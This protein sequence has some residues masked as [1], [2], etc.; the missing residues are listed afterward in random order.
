MSVL[1]QVSRKGRC[2]AHPGLGPR[3]VRSYSHF[4][5]IHMAG[6]AGPVAWDARGARLLGSSGRARQR[7]VSPM[8]VHL[9][10]VATT[11]FMFW[12][13]YLLAV[14]APG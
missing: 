7:D 3:G 9:L 1:T 5:R 8:M 4:R 11:M 10:V 14:H 13:L 2:R 12:D 6:A